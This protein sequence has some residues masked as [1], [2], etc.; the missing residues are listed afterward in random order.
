MPVGGPARGAS[1][2]VS[3][4]AGRSLMLMYC[5]QRSL[6]ITFGRKV[7]LNRE[8]AV[9]SGQ[10]RGE[11]FWSTNSFT[12]PR[13]QP[14]AARDP[15]A[16]S[17]PDASSSAPG[18]SGPT[19]VGP[20]P[21]QTPILALCRRI[22]RPASSADTELPHSRPDAATASRSRARS[23]AQGAAGSP[24]GAARIRSLMQEMSSAYSASRRRWL[25]RVLVH[26]RVNGLP[27]RSVTCSMSSPRRSMVWCSLTGFPP[28]HF[29]RLDE[30]DG[31][32]E[33]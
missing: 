2:W 31:D 24:I 16:S 30:A 28:R 15:R 13:P 26:T 6:R 3:P 4:E 11:R 5:A 12:V 17:R 33:R 1:S 8:R 18:S 21:A 32:A 27:R 25:A 19:C 7:I 23:G 20:S 10:S 22:Q 9:V 14:V 29:V